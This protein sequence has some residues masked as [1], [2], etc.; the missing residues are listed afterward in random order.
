MGKESFVKR[1]SYFIFTLIVVAIDQITKA[2]IVKTIE[3]GRVKFSFLKD[4]IWICHVR[5]SAIGFSIGSSLNDNLKRFLFIL[6]PLIVLILLVVFLFRNKEL[7]NYQKFFVGGIIGGGI[8]NLIDRIFRVDWVVDFI[9][10]KVYGFLGF[11]RWPTFNVAD[12]T[13]VVCTVLLLFSLFFGGRGKGVLN[14]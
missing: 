14:E 4:F 3:E 10:I 5:N 13:I 8:G 11:E 6:V 9:S 12:A 7:E 2:W 1:H